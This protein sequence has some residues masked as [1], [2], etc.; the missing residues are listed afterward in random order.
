M[1]DIFEIHSWDIMILNSPDRMI[2]NRLI[3]TTSA[4]KEIT[5]FYQNI[6]GISISEKKEGSITFTLGHTKLEFKGSEKSTPYHFAINI[7]SNKA[8]GAL[9]WLNDRIEILSDG[10]NELIEFKSWNAESIYFYDTDRNIVEL[11]ARKNLGIYVDKTFSE[12]YFLGIS[13][14]GM[15]VDNI[16][17]IFLDLNRIKKIEIYD[18]SF[19]SFCALGDENGLFIVID[20]YKKKWFPCGDT[21]FSSPFCIEGDFNFKFRN[22]SILEF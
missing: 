16:E 7:P 1:P 6:L 2:V 12:K 18:G 15:P 13:E 11:I 14:I 19:D 20:K 10:N 4:L 17:K 22:G 8:K 21:A 9:K 3:L 5:D